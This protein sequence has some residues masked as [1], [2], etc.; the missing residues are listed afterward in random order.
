[1]LQYT[2]QASALNSAC[3]NVAGFLFRSEV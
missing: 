1:M 2:R 3:P